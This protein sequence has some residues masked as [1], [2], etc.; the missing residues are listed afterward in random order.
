MVEINLG[1]RNVVDL[2]VR[3]LVRW[4]ICVFGTVAWGVTSGGVIV[5]V[6]SSR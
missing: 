3:V 6:G 5:I 4:F 2:G 1:A